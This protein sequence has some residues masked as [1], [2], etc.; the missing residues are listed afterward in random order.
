MSDDSQVFCK[1]DSE[2]KFFKNTGKVEYIDNINIFA[3][4]KKYQELN[5]CLNII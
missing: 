5:A 4:L 2:F 1:Y 3:F